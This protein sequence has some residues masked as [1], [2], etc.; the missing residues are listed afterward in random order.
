MCS[1][2]SVEHLI[3][4]DI[5]A[6]PTI[7]QCIVASAIFIINLKTVTSSEKTPIHILGLYPMSGAWPGGYALREASQFAVDH[8][9]S[10]QSILPDYEIV[11]DA[12]DSAVSILLFLFIFSKGCF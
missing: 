1:T 6:W 8:V 3:L 4:R 11:I 10:N 2:V 5:M 12:A 7:I 9:N